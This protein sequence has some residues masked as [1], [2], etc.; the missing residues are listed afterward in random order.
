MQRIGKFIAAIL[1]A[2]SF[3]ILISSDNLFSSK[4][5]GCCKQRKLI[6][7]L[8]DKNSLTFTE[9]EKLNNNTDGN[10]NLLLPEGLVWWDLN[11]S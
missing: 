8:W 1:I 10:D 6:N 7:E 11:C 9:C 4:E 2:F 3:L 5:P